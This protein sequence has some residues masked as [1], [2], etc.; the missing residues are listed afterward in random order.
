MPDVAVVSFAGSEWTEQTKQKRTRVYYR[1]LA[2]ALG[3]SR[4]SF[5]HKH[6]AL[7][8][9][10]PARENDLF[11]S[12]LKEH[13]SSASSCV[14]LDVSEYQTRVPLFDHISRSL[15]M[16]AQ[17]KLVVVLVSSLQL[18]M[19]SQGLLGVKRRLAKKGRAIICVE[20][21][22]GA[23][24]VIGASQTHPH[25]VNFGR[26]VGTEDD[27]VEEI[28]AHGGSRYYGHH[29]LSSPSDWHLGCFVDIVPAI[30][31]ERCLQYLIH[32]VSNLAL[33]KEATALVA[34]GTCDRALMEFLGA[35]RHDVEGFEAGYLDT[36]GRDVD[37]ST[38]DGKNVVIVTDVVQRGQT[39]SDAISRVR[40]AGGVPVAVF[41]LLGNTQSPDAC[42]DV[43]IKYGGKTDSF[44]AHSPERCPVQ[45]PSISDPHYDDY[46]T[47]PTLPID[48]FV[49]WSLAFRANAVCGGHQELHNGRSHF[50]PFI[51]TDYMIHDYGD[52]LARSLV[53][54]LLIGTT[55]V[56][57]VIVCP[58]EAPALSLSQLVLSELRRK[59]HPASDDVVAVPRVLIESSTPDRLPDGA[60]SLLAGLENRD[61]LLVDDCA[62]RLVTRNNLNYMFKLARARLWAFAVLLCR[63]SYDKMTSFDRYP[64]EI[65]RYVY[66]FPVPPWDKSSCPVC[67]ANRH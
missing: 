1:P 17:N 57:P 51:R 9:I 46:V 50:M 34:V 7:R 67:N 6:A 42:A 62:N 18:T 47:L 22:S 58:D 15:L 54:A 26:W 19:M 61:I 40:A 52:W 14:L 23:V 25:R 55:S 49:F 10:G 35:V 27:F 24:Q 12:Q 28:L 43:P 30:R 63:L 13:I 37:A 38:V 59:H 64:H 11:A 4:P 20:R 16:I 66:H 44:M 29:R 31:D 60:E 39:V 32:R 56:A 48:P 36:P 5:S 33:E 45:P 53:Q 3:L 65:F 41:S 21:G 8:G 2:R